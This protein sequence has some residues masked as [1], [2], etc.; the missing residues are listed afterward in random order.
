[1]AVGHAG[2]EALASGGATMAAGH[3]GRC[4]RLIDEHQ[5]GRIEIELTIKPGLSPDQDVRTA[6]LVRVRRL[7]LSVI[8]RLRDCQ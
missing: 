2:L 6:L 5:P 1:M 4:P 7:F 8:R 3:L